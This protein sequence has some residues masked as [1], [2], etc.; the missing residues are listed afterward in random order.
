MLRLFRKAIDN[1]RQFCDKISAKQYIKKLERDEETVYFLCPHGIGDTLFVASLIDSYKKTHMVKRVVLI[2]KKS[3]EALPDMF[4]AVDGKIVSD[5]L[6]RKLTD[7]ARKNRI[8]KKGNFRFGHF[9]LDFDWPEP[10]QLLGVR[11]INILDIYRSCI[12]RVLPE[13]KPQSPEAYVSQDTLNTMIRHYQKDKKT[14]L[15]MPYASTIGQLSKSFWEF[16][17]QLLIENGYI[18]YTNTKDCNETSIKGTEA[19]SLPIKDLFVISRTLKWS[20]V[21]LRSGI[22]DLL[23]YSDVSLT[24]L[25]E[26]AALYVGWNLKNLGLP[27]QN[28]NEIVLPS[29]FDDKVKAELVY[30]RAIKSEMI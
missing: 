12:L 16:L 23:G 10:G 9:I 24:V 14:F 5:D 19:I 4:D 15:L 21:S 17:A 1:I 25:Y 6:V 27:N 28:I 18:V 2:V 29:D 3:H 11:G 22:C 30:N 7:Y 20:C 26:N 8:F 13:T